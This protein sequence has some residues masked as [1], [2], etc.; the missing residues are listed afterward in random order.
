MLDAGILGEDDRV[1]LIDGEILQMAPI[2]MRHIMCVTRL[3]DLLGEQLRRR[4]LVSPQNSLILDEG[5][6]FQPDVAVLKLRDYRDDEL[7]PQADDALLVIEVSDTTVTRD[8]RVKAPRYARAGIPIY[9]LINLPRNT[10]EAYSNPI[11]GAYQQVQH[12]KRGDA[13]E[14]AGFS[15][16]SIMV[17]DVLG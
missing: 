13:L 12:L 7:A 1:E 5:T 14:L 15:D 8:Q 17:D 9:W 2:R 4:A 6:E 11:G 3:V 16:V 10:V